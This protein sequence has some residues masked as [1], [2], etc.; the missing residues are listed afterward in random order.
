MSAMYLSVGES[1][2][3]RYRIVRYMTQGGMG[4]IYEAEDL[5]PL[6]ERRERADITPAQR[7]VV[8]TIL[9]AKADD[10]DLVTRFEREARIGRRIVHENVSHTY[11]Y[12][13][14]TITLPD[15]SRRDLIFL[16]MPFFEGQTL[17]AFLEEKKRPLT[18]DET[19]PL[20]RQMANG[21]AAIHK[22][23]A[24]HR[25]FK[26]SNVMLI[27]EDQGLRAVILDFGIA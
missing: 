26:S 5:G 10:P 11:D 17:A 13:Y 22:A 4:A 25:D 18:V 8:K 9:P 15:G 14:H 20:L 27:S 12:G 21:L 6:G 19:L 23:D 24:V 7:V 16:V 3:D 2:A 1:I